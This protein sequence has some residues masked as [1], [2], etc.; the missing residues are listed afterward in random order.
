MNIIN[1]IKDSWNPVRGLHQVEARVV[2]GKPFTKDRT[3]E[4]GVYWT[5]HQEAAGRTAKE[6][7][8]QEAG[9]QTSTLPTSVLNI[10]KSQKV[11]TTRVSTKW[12]MGKQEAVYPHSRMNSAPRRTEGMLR[13][14][15]CCASEMPRWVKEVTDRQSRTWFDSHETFAIGTSTERADW[16]LPGVREGGWV[17]TAW[18]KQDSLEG[19]ANVLWQIEVVV[20]KHCECVECRWEVYFNVILCPFH[21]NK[22]VTRLV[23][24]QEHMTHIQETNQLIEL[25][26]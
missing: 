21:L 7:D 3:K 15:T 4:T 20:T 26:P 16:Q 25:D 12:G 17:V 5:Q 9:V 10:H 24:K 6:R 1:A 23:R 22:K 19:D 2:A 18:W 13:S 8:C 14:T 11:E